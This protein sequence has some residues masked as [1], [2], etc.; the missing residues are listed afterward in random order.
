MDVVDQASKDAYDRLKTLILRRF[1]GDPEKRRIIEAFENDPAGPTDTLTQALSQSGIP[2]D[3]EALEAAHLLL[4]HRDP[5]GAARGTYTVR[6]GGN[7]QGIVV[8]DRN[9]V[10]FQGPLKGDP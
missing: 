10:T 6:V 5:E 2:H 7:A 1:G 9:R 4:E 3:V 8:G